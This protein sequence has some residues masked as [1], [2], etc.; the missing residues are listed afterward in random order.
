MTLTRTFQARIQI[1]NWILIIALVAITIYFIW[2]KNGILITLS[3]LFL[4]LIIERGIHTEY[5]L[6]NESLTIHKGR[7]SKDIIIPI[8]QIKRI[9]RIRKFRTGKKAL[10]TYLV[11]VY[12]D[13]K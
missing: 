8:E 10:I 1:S 12:S 4:L 3:L 6:N 2:E 7:L 9:E 13:E 5:R 11:V